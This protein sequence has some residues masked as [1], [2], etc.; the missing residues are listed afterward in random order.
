MTSVKSKAN[1]PA[2]STEPVFTG[3]V[4][5]KGLVFFFPS[6]GI[7]APMANGK[8]DN[9]LTFTE[10]EWM[11]WGAGLPDADMAKASTLKSLESKAETKIV[12]HSITFK[13]NA[14]KADLECAEDLSGSYTAGQFMDLLDRLSND[15]VDVDESMVALK[16]AS[17]EVV[18]KRKGRGGGG[19][20]TNRGGTSDRHN[21]AS[22]EV[23]VKESEIR[24]VK[25]GSSAHTCLIAL[26]QG[27]GKD[28][29]TVNEI[30]DMNGFEA[31][32]VK[33]QAW[34]VRQVIAQTGYGL[35]NNKLVMPEGMAKIKT[36]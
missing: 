35:K 1:K 31:Y 17:I 29:A 11:K 19:S 26:Q 23:A 27:K 18:V 8:P 30:A 13:L 10:E 9:S 21:R 2:Q 33:R 34:K 16:S 32:D 22:L 15:D 4:S 28:Q 5:G 20:S 3:K 24:A 7:Y 14:V 36:H 6:E 12:K 25:Y